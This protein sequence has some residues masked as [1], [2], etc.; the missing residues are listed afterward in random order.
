MAPAI[1]LGGGE[2]GV[3]QGQPHLAQ[4]VERE[5]HLALDDGPGRDA[6]R[7]RHALGHGLRRR[8]GP[9]THPR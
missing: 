7:G 3:A 4:I 9:E 5:V 1:A 6:G 2:V 8:P